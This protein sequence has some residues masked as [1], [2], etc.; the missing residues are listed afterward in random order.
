MNEVVTGP[1]TLREDLRQDVL[2]LG[3]GNMHD[4]RVVFTPEVEHQDYL[5]PGSPWQK[6]EDY[7]RLHLHDQ[8]PE[9][10]QKYIDKVDGFAKASSM[11]LHDLNE[12]PYPWA[13]EAYDEIHAYEV[14]EHCGRQGDGDFF[15]GQFN[16]FWR[17]LKPGG[18]FCLSVPMWDSEVAWGVPDHVRVLPPGIFGFLT[19]DY[20]NNIGKPG[21]GDYRHMLDG[22][23][24]IA[25]AKHETEEQLNV[26]LRKLPRE[27]G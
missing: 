26:V 3:C 25:V 18:Y 27:N 15:F 23:Y 21:Y 19:K 14:L 8:V 16:E 6:F 7:A 2:L 13:D 22:R 24:W 4:K 10:I 20:Y 1:A 5:G 9:L 12:L 11:M 17:M